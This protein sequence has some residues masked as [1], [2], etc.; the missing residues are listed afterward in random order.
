MTELYL[1]SMNGRGLAGRLKR[2]EIFKWAKEKRVD[3]LFLQDTHWTPELD[4]YI[5]S[6]WGYKAYL[7]TYKSNSRGV[8]IFINNTFE[9]EISKIS[10]DIYGN[11][12]LL[13]IIL[14][15]IVTIVIGLIFGPNTDSPTFYQNLFKELEEFENPNTILVGDWN[16]TL[17]F[18][19]DNLN[20]IHRNNVNA[21]NTI[22]DLI[23][24]HGWV[25]FWRTLHPT[26]KK[27]TWSQPPLNLLGWIFFI[28]SEELLNI[29]SK[30]KI[31]PKWKSD[32]APISIK[33][34]ITKQQRG[35]GVWKFNDSILADKNFKPFILKEIDKLRAI[36]AATPYNPDFISQIPNKDLQLNIT[37][38]LFWK[39]LMTV[40][41]GEII[42]YAA[43]KKKE[44]NQEEDKLNVRIA[45]LAE[46]EL[47]ASINENEAK[48]LESLIEQ[49]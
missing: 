11:Y 35:K 22:N 17:N 21:T 5:I 34:N 18:D 24:S 20:Y 28:G 4:N 44:A 26:T 32:H 29:I 41:R 36:Y 47:R 19:L 1:V 16:L 12:L 14:L 33:L 48:E 15:G 6:E 25:D 9:C 49:L 30:A 46:K 45:K 27:F 8:A 39:T 31:E 2:R 43:K 3:I 10:R 7:A 42:S 37:F 13:E 38:I 23:K 40:L